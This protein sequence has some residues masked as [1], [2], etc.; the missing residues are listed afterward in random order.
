VLLLSVDRSSEEVCSW[1][2]AGGIDV[3]VF[4]VFAHG[5]C[6]YVCMY[7]RLYCGEYDGSIERELEMN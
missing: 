4:R 7:E 6:M 5:G 3:V 2:Y 1:V